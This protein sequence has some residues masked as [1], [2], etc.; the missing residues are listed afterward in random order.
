MQERFWDFAIAGLRDFGI[1]GLRDFGIEELRDFGIED[2][3]D[4]FSHP[5][6]NKSQNQK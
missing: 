1:S 2:F 4:G 6:I 5:N 3:G